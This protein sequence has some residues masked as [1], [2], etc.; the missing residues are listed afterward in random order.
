M[1]WDPFGKSFDLDMSDMV[2][3]WYHSSSLNKIEEKI[4]Y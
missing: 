4:P 3:T 1:S 2:E